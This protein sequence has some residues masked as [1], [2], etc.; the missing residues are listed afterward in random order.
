MDQP[1][2]TQSR[3]MKL[4]PEELED[5]NGLLKMRKTI[6][7][8][9]HVSF[10]DIGKSGPGYVAC[11]TESYKVPEVIPLTAAAK[12]DLLDNSPPCHPWTIRIRHL[13]PEQHPPRRVRKTPVGGLR[14]A[15]P[16]GTTMSATPE[17]TLLKVDG[18]RL[19][20][21]S[22]SHE[23]RPDPSRRTR[24][25]GDVYEDAVRCIC[26]ATAWQYHWCG[27]RSITGVTEP[28]RDRG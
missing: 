16:E 17:N 19:E 3:K 2:D 22:H 6:G 11:T 13:L 1:T 20:I 21:S 10:E 9:P 12:L 4:A 26:G 5:D 15:N 24:L 18:N 25:H 7:E 27:K 23:W 8:K 14:P 28:H